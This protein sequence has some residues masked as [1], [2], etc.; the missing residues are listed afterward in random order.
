MTTA[1]AVE[2]LEAARW[3]QATLG[4]DTLL[5][6]E[7]PGKVWSQPAPAE[8]TGTWVTHQL[9]ADHD[10]KTANAATIWSEELWLVRAWAETKDYELLGPA[11]ARIH[12]LLVNVRNFPTT[13]N[14]TV[15]SCYREQTWMQQEIDSGREFRSLGGLYR[16]CIQLNGS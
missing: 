16:I 10:V 6:A 7:A 3:L 11:A 9:Q 8:V 1:V 14:A 5:L 15:Y 2:Q 13:A 4:G 12:Q